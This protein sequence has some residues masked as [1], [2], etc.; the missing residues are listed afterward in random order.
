MN[1]AFAASNR[2]NQPRPRGMLDPTL[3]RPFSLRCSSPLPRLRRSTGSFDG[4][5]CAYYGMLQT[6]SALEAGTDNNVNSISNWLAPRNTTSWKKPRW[7]NKK[8]ARR[9]KSPR[10]SEMHKKEEPQAGRCWH[11]PP[12]PRHDHRR[13]HKSVGL[14]PRRSRRALLAAALLPA[15]EWSWPRHLHHSLASS[16]SLRNLCARSKLVA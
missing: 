4:V 3:A 13:R 16:R 6:Q 12:A 8:P 5:S 11:C 14:S 1:V 10:R 9:L 2:V 7:G 15:K